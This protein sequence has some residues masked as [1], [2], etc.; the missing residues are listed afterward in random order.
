MTCLNNPS[1]WGNR[2]KSLHFGSGAELGPQMC[3]SLGQFR[4]HWYPQNLL[5][6]WGSHY[7]T[8]QDWWHRKTLRNV[9]LKASNASSSPALG[10]PSVQLSFF[11]KSAVFAQKELVCQGARRG[12]QCF[13]EGRETR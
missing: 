3:F 8:Q 1:A 11:P 5:L 13:A 2:V 10:H 7:G 6:L 12:L 4:H 9:V